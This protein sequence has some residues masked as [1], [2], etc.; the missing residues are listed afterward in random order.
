L[1]PAATGETP[2]VHVQQRTLFPAKCKEAGKKLRHACRRLKLKRF[3]QRELL[4][5]LIKRLYDAGVPVKRNA[6]CQGHRD[7]GRLIQ[8]VY[9]EVFCDTDKA[10]EEADLAKVGASFLKVVAK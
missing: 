3:K 10:A 6:L 7:G 1:A 8:E 4:A 2:G 9:T 5:M